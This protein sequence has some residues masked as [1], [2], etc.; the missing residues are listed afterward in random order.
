MLVC[1]ECRRTITC[2][3]WAA[4]RA[5][6]PS[7][8]SQTSEIP[9]WR[10]LLMAE[11]ALD[12]GAL[13]SRTR[14]LPTAR[15][16]REAAALVGCLAAPASICATLERATVATMV[17]QT[18]R[19]IRSRR[20]KSRCLQTREGGGEASSDRR[21]SGS[22]GRRSTATSSDLSPARGCAGGAP[23]SR[24]VW[25]GVGR[26]RAP[27][28]ARGAAALRWSPP[29]VPLRDRIVGGSRKRPSNSNRA[30]QAHP[31]HSNWQCTTVSPAG[32][33]H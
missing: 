27:R 13:R 21:R 25:G 1:C 5:A 2:Q 20:R 15:L 14:T 7:Q 33:N 6:W 24:S 4:S 8:A 18:I 3:A 9:S 30:R 22:L 31:L 16:T 23:G 28:A 19:N 12:R 29:S 17:L 32:S 11:T 26:R 10:Y